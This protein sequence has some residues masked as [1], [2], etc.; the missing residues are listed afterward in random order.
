MIIKNKRDYKIPLYSLFSVWQ[1]ERQKGVEG[2]EGHVIILRS[3][4]IKFIHMTL[5]LH[6]VKGFNLTGS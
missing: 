2:R 1:R 4:W 3:N 5:L 6:T